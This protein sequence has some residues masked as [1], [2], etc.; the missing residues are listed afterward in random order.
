MKIV[1]RYI[2]VY[3]VKQFSQTECAWARHSISKAKQE[4]GIYL[5]GIY[6]VVEFDHSELLNMLSTGKGELCIEKGSNNLAR[7]L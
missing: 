7:P 2:L 5:V 6:P 4:V 3:D 1:Y